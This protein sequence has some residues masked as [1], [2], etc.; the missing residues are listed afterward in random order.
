[1]IC[2]GIAF[3]SRPQAIFKLL[4]KRK[5]RETKTTESAIFVKID[6]YPDIKKWARPGVRIQTIIN[7]MNF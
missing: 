1:V 3:N 2:F 7:Y 4:K 5:K 6:F